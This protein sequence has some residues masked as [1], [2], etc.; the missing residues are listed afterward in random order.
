[1][2]SKYQHFAVTSTFT[3]PN[4]SYYLTKYK[5]NLDFAKSSISFHQP[6]TRIPKRVFNQKRGYYRFGYVIFYISLFT[7]RF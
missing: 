4:K 2:T 5:Y 7:D 6:C 1:M 3:L